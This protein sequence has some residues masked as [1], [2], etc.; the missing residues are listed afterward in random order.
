MLFHCGALVVRARRR[1]RSDDEEVLVSVQALMASASGQDDDIS[2][3]QREC[4][5]FV[6]SEA[7]APLAA[8]DAEHLMDP[9]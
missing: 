8:R 5:S 9:W 6:A 2:G 1:I 7:D 3:P 4:P